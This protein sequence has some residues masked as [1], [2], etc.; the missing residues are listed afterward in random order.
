MH[1]VHHEGAV[2]P[3]FA[4]DLR[5]RGVDDEPIT[6]LGEVDH[7]AHIDRNAACLDPLAVRC[8]AVAEDDLAELGLIGALLCLVKVRLAPEGDVEVHKLLLRRDLEL[9]GFFLLRPAFEVDAAVLHNI[10]HCDLHVVNEDEKTA[11]DF[12]GG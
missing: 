2:C 6:H 1:I 7:L 5:R 4:E 10:L 9:V 12:F 8:R 11:S 3:H